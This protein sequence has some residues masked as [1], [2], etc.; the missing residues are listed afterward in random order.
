MPTNDPRPTKAVRRDEARA[1]AAQMRK[2]QER[3]ARRNRILAISGLVVAVVALVA[4][5]FSILNQNKANEA[6]NSNVTYGQGAENVVAPA[7]DDVT[8]P[9]PANDKGGIPVSGSGGDDVGTA[10]DGDVDLTI[11]FDYM[12]PY[13]GQFDETNAGDLDAMLE[14]GGVTITYHPVSI[15]DHLSAGSSY[16]TRTVNATAIVADKS[17]EHFTDFVTALYKDQPEEGTS[18]RSDAEIA[19]IAEDLGV[20][21]EV[22][23]TFTDTVDGTFATQDEESVEGTWRIFAPWSAATTAQAGTDRP[24][25][26]TP[27]VLI[28]GEPFQDWQTPGALKQAVDAAKS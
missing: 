17:P 28:N 9:A 20:P 27:T 25:F 11:Y 16:S 10:G 8:A 22:T 24:E 13:C 2:E 21:A 12:C 15:L 14:E 23:A 4:V 5:V 26:S 3:K 7:L 19:Q 18:G 6:A 1:K